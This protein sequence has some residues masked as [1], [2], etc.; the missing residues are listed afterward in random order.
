MGREIFPLQNFGKMM[1]VLYHLV[2]SKYPEHCHWTYQKI[3][4]A[5]EKKFDLKIDVFSN[6]EPSTNN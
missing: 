4:E 5:F 1:F 3:L 6:F 2:R